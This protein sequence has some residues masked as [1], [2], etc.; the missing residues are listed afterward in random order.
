MVGVPGRTAMANRSF[1]EIF[2]LRMAD[3]CERNGMT[4]MQLAQA[5]NL[6]PST[7]SKIEAGRSLPSLMNCMLICRVL[8]I[9]LDQLVGGMTNGDR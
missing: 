6:N 7:I 2:G 5:C 1:R 9:K 8:G 4:Q 3:F